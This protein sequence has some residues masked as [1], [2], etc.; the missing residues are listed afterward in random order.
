MEFVMPLLMIGFVI[1]WLYKPTWSDKRRRKR[2]N[3]ER[4]A[5]LPRVTRINGKKVL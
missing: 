4:K 2:L 1:Y 5:M 3:E